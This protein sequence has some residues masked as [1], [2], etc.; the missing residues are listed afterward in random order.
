MSLPVDLQQPLEGIAD[1]ISFT[2]AA[3][4]LA[5]SEATLCQLILMGHLTRVSERTVA[6]NEVDDLAKQQL[7]PGQRTRRAKG[8]LPRTTEHA[9]W[10]LA[11]WGGRGRVIGLAA[12]LEV[13]WQNVH[14]KITTAVNAGYVERAASGQHPAHYRLTRDGWRYIRT[15]RSLI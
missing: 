12:A 10:L 4:K 5:V 13:S 11:D 9:L 6:R 1:D 15:H 7:K 2:S 14:A 3:E 8:R